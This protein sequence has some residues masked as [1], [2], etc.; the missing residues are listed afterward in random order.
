[1]R[2]ASLPAVILAL[3]CGRPAA[4]PGP[5]PATLATAE[6]LYLDTR[7]LRDR[8]DVELERSD[9]HID[10]VVRDT[11]RGISAD[12]LP[13]I[14]DRFRQAD[15]SSTRAHSG[16]GL[17]LALAK[18]LMELHGGTLTAHSDG[19]GTGATVGN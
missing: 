11:G 7:D 19:E 1:M 5:S 14:F 8:I 9:L 15:S 2:A 10:I 17:G 18:N 16:L 4:P 13:F 6:S 3:G 12:V